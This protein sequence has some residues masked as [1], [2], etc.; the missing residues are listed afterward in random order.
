[1]LEQLCN[2]GRVT[3]I[4]EPVSS[5]VSQGRQ[6]GP[7]GLLGGM[8]ERPALGLAHTMANGSLSLFFFFPF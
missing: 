2:L 1:M 3:F 5:I 6:R 8:G 7:L 4:S